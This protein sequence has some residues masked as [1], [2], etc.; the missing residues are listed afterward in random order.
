MD[1]VKQPLWAEAM[2]EHWEELRGRLMWSTGALLAG[3]VVS[4]FWGATRVI[5]WLKAIMPGSVL[6]V[7]LAPGEGFMVCVKVALWLGVVLSSPVWV[8]HTLRFVMPGLTVHER[9]WVG[10]L[11]VLGLLLFAVG[12]G[13]GYGVVL[14]PALGF[15]VE[16]GQSVAALQLSIGT[17][18]DFCL[19]VLVMMGICFEL[20][21]GM[22]VLGLVGVVR[23]NMVLSQWRMVVLGCAFMAAFITPSQDPIT[24]LLVM[25]ALLVLLLL[26]G[27]VLRLLGK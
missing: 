16:M 10:V 7:Q 9:R 20:P 22:V 4:W 6:F 27:G 12:V 14:G 2:Q 18:V 24:M 5:T 25:G 17:Y 26:G 23:S 1:D 8:Y 3:I 15:L 21:I 11:V 19:A 13:F